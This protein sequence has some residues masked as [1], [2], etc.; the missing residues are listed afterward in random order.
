MP[1]TAGLTP[2]QRAAKRFAVGS[3]E[4]QKGQL[5]RIVDGMRGRMDCLGQV[6]AF[7]VG[8]GVLTPIGLA[9]CNITMNKKNC[10]QDEKDEQGEPD[11]P[12]PPE[13]QVKDEDIEIAKDHEPDIPCRA[14]SPRGPPTTWDRNWTNVGKLG[15]M[16]IELL[17]RYRYPQIFTIAN[18]RSLKRPGAKTILMH[19]LQH[20]IEYLTNWDPT[21]FI[22]PE[23]RYQEV[24][25]EFFSKQCGYLGNRG[26]TLV[27]EPSE[28]DQWLQGIYDWEIK[29]ATMLSLWHNF[30]PNA[31]KVLIIPK[32]ERD[33]QIVANYSEHKA[34]LKSRTSNFSKPLAVVFADVINNRFT[35][36][37][38]KRCKLEKSANS[39]S[40]HMA[41]PVGVSTSPASSVLTD[42]KVEHPNVGPTAVIP[43][44]AGSKKRDR[45]KPPVLQ[46]EVA[47]VAT[48]AGSKRTRAKGVS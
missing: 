45:P 28:E 6:D 20:Y 27:L 46:K 37:P 38:V 1:P 10:K 30:E 5:I 33:F 19:R 32:G 16:F 25:M 15:P 23:H 29:S 9:E 17:L 36:K 3:H 4:F 8:I 48:S 35:A 47:Q 40:Q 26:T 14:V 21:Q 43:Q 34:I 31:I 39:E 7:L 18:M 44:S 2:A 12:E 13:Q 11:D 24:Y 22:Q 41:Q 42:A